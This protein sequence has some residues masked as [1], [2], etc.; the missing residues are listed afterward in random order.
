MRRARKEEL[1]SPKSEA[2]TPT[3]R[4]RPRRLGE[5]QTASGCD[6]TR[7]GVND[8]EVRACIV[9]KIK[10]VPPKIEGS[11]GKKTGV[12]LLRK[13]VKRKGRVWCVKS[14]QSRVREPGGASAAAE[15]ERADDVW[16]S[17]VQVLFPRVSRAHRRRRRR[18]RQGRLGG[19]SPRPKLVEI[20][21]RQSRRQKKTR[22]V[23]G[24]EEADNA[25]EVASLVAV[26]EGREEEPHGAVV[27]LLVGRLGT[28]GPGGTAARRGAAHFVVVV[29][30]RARPLEE[31]HVRRRVS[32]ARLGADGEALLREQMRRHRGIGVHVGG[33]VGAPRVGTAGV[34]PRGDRAVGEQLGEGGLLRGQRARVGRRAEEVGAHDGHLLLELVGGEERGELALVV[35]PGDVGGRAAVV[36]ERARVAAEEQ[37]VRRELEVARDVA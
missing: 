13:V 22:G 9:T 14:F 10:A 3:G 23:S 32:R 11:G 36:V 28:S 35:L 12:L 31:H 15:P 5:R 19:R 2:T 24:V 26:R 37:E 16:N 18:R 29:L 17:L 6:Q 8:T 34:G 20:R 27:L 30:R 33:G 4:R 25:L 1:P 7:Q 21:R